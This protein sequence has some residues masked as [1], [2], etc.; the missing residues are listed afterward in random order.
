VEPQHRLHEERGRDS[1]KRDGKHEGN[2]AV[3]V[4]EAT[5]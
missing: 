2:C 4:R 5:R 1:G 3:E